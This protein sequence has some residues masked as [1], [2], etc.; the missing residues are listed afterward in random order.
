MQDWVQK[1]YGRVDVF[2]KSWR[3]VRVKLDFGRDGR[4]FG[5][6]ARRQLELRALGPGSQ[7]ANVARSQ[8]RTCSCR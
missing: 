4:T 8:L 6:D 7:V 3:L 1:R 2:E 5:T